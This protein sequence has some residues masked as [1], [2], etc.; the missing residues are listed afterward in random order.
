MI[1]AEEDEDIE[2]AAAVSVADPMQ[3][4]MSTMATIEPRNDPLDSAKVFD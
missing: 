4:S 2:V 1:D 3:I